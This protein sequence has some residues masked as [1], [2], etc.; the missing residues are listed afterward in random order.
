MEHPEYWM[1]GVYIGRFYSVYVF[2]CGSGL[3]GT[4]VYIFLSCIWYLQS[5]GNTGVPQE[6]GYKFKPPG[7][8]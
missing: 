6:E 5:W 1:R 3:E 4:Y 2:V 8:S 7:Q